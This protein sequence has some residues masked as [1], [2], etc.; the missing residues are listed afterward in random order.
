MQIT[1]TVHLRLLADRVALILT[2]EFTNDAMQQGLLALAH[3][4]QYY[5]Y[6]TIQFLINSVGGEVEALQTLEAA[7]EWYRAQ[8][9]RIVTSAWGRAHSA[10]AIALTLGD[11]GWRI[12]RSD[13]TIL[14]HASRF[15]VK[16]QTTIEP[17]ALE[18]MIRIQEAFLSQY[19][20]K[21]VCRANGQIEDLRERNWATVQHQAASAGFSRVNMAVTASASV[22]E[23]PGEPDAEAFLNLF[24][25]ESIL[26]AAQASRWSL[27]DHVVV[28][29]DD[30][31]ATW[32]A[33]LC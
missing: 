15:Q 27:V 23:P 7:M 18:S 29:P 32:L 5:R 21:L 31:M 22:L 26:S 24:R 8:G 1:N 25:E 6:E 13:T 28:S 20:R 33:G 3:A 9:K 10:A 19:V 12:V 11:P 30:E 16:Q 4:V 14:L 17:R 2:G